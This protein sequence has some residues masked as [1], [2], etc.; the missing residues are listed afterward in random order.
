MGKKSSGN[1]P[2]I[3]E[4]ALKSAE[5]G[6]DYLAWMKDQSKI[7]NAWADEDRGRYKSVFE[8]LQDQ[9]IEEAQAYDTAE[10]RGT[11]AREA[12]ADVKTQSL[13]AKDAAGREMARMGVDP[14]SGRA[15]A[16]TGAMTLREGLAAA[17]AANSARKQVESEGRALKA[18][19]V[20]LGSGFAVNPATSLGMSSSAMSSGFNGAMS[21]QNQMASLLTQQQQMKNASAD[22][23]WGGIGSV[24]GMGLAIFSSKDFKED[25]KPARG[26]LEALNKMPVE[27][28]TYKAG[29]G[30][31]GRHVGPYA[32]DFKDATG[33]G[34]GKT[35][36]VVDAIGVT[37]GAVQELSAKVDKIAK[38]VKPRSVM[39]Y[40][41]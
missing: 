25:K 30:D 11:A 18:N 27:E 20:N 10:R 4:A 31:E 23:L 5:L 34:D 35:I 16:T 28:W 32:E 36:P 9:F 3:G 24:A 8:P 14:R 13:M 40:A 15:A 26:V 19:A 17:G 29:A 38:A 7:S 21:G 22:S 2:R 6:E 41:K 1:D 12:V 37:M 39:E 33:K